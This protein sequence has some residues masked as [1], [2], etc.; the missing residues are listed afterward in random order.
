MTNKIHV[1]ADESLGGVKR[2]YVEVKRKAEV[3]DYVTYV[4][5]GNR[6]EVIVTAKEVDESGGILD[7]EPW[8]ISEDEGDETCGFGAEAYRVL[9][10]TDIVHIE[11]DDGKSERYRMVDRNAEVGERVIIVE[12]GS[13]DFAVG[14]ITEI[15]CVTDNGVDEQTRLGDAE[16]GWLYEE[17]YL[18]LES[19]ESGTSPQSTDDIIANLVR[20]V[21]SLERQVTE[22]ERE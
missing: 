6:D 16:Y 18:V 22:L 3:G 19:V 2:E 12:A 9:E 7:I 8:Y 13:H 21:S 11:S 5:N 20:R 1:L 10:P 17:E 4:Y 15:K 14:D